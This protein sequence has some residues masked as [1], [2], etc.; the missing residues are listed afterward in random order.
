MLPHPTSRISPLVGHH[1]QAG[2]PSPLHHQPSPGPWPDHPAPPSSWPQ[3]VHWISSYP[4]A[5]PL[6]QPLS[7]SS[8]PDL[9]QIS[10]GLLQQIWA[11]IQA[12]SAGHQRT[13]CRPSPPPEQPWRVPPLAALLHGAATDPTDQPPAAVAEFPQAGTRFSAQAASERRVLL[14]HARPSS[15]TDTVTFSS[16]LA[17]LPCS[18]MA[19]NDT[20]ATAAATR[21]ATRTA[22][23][24]PDQQRRQRASGDSRP[25]RR[26]RDLQIA[27]RSSPGPW[28]PSYAVRQRRAAP[29]CPQRRLAR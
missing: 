24:D 1:H 10:S 2:S 19:R 18:P 14:I 28:L 4:L 8:S 3:P 22:D 15:E 29:Q 16:A 27:A 9:Q 5:C 6:Q 13:S 25:F 21:P 11:A 17:T 23:P 7:S 20:T 12:A 26:A